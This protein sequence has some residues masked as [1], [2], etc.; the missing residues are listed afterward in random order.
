MTFCPIN[1]SYL[2]LTITDKCDVLFKILVA[3]PCEWGWNL[4]RVGPSLTITFET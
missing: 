4:F 2:S 1:F 3:L